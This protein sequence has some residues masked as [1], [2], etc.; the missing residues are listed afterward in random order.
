MWECK[1][2]HKK[3][4]KRPYGLCDCGEFESFVEVSSGSKSIPSRKGGSGG[5]G[6]STTQS[7]SDLSFNKAVSL[8]NIKPEDFSQRLKT[9]FN[10]CDRVL[11]G[12]FV[13]GGIV[14]LAGTPGAGKSTLCLAIAGN[15]ANENRKVV[16]ISGEE[17]IN[18]IALRA[19]R[20]GIDN[21]HI[22]LSHETQA[23]SIIEYCEEYKPALC[24]VDSVQTLTVS[25]VSSSA[26]S[27]TQSKE[28]TDML[29][30][31]GKQH[32]IP[33]ILISQ[34]VKSGDFSGSEAIQHIVDAT[35]KLELDKISPLRFLR[36]EKNR[37]G[38]TDEVGV[39]QHVDTGLEE[40]TDPTK[41]AIDDD[42]V[43]GSSGTAISMLSEGARFFPVE[44]QSLAIPSA[45]GNPRKIF[46][47][48]NMGKA[49]GICAIIDKFCKTR[50]SDQ[51]IYIN[52]VSH[53]KVDSPTCDLAIA[54]SL[55]TSLKGMDMPEGYLYVGELS[56]TGAI[57]STSSS[58]NAG[59]EAVR[60]GYKNI[61]VP[62]SSKKDIVKKVS[63]YTDANTVNIVGIKNINDL[64]R[65]I[66]SRGTKNVNE[67]KL[68]ENQ[69]KAKDLNK[70]TNK[71][72]YNADK[73]TE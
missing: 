54:V 50:L 19:Q 29:T 47:G 56:L 5:K 38:S 7:L 2:C 40:I 14:L 59:S 3:F 28:V 62:Y 49:H 73:N 10:E 30:M 34:V 48:V 27:I 63:T 22:Y 39:F 67:M 61:I 33:M 18:Q 52:T 21:E 45:L 65:I 26:G 32:S 53:V 37:F 11:G 64:Y 17:S 60:L 20:M 31:Y 15:V 6:K 12:G 36:A 68:K 69:R 58:V 72:K 4:S 71:N 70:Y 35:L 8:K 57:R 9:G 23:E 42:S 55:I 13:P 16:Y 43:Q 66:S 24:I 46:N 1:D 41:I 25:H 44:I 51:D